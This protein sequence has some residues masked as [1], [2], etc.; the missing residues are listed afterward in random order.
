MTQKTN[1]C[2]IE[3]C[4][5]PASAR[6]LCPRHYVR[7]RRH[8]DPTVV[9]PPGAPRNVLKAMARQAIGIPDKMSERTFNRFWRAMG[10][11]KWLGANAGEAAEQRIWDAARRPNGRFNVSKLHDLAVEALRSAVKANPNLLDKED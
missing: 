10:I 11:L 9:K 8:G 2:A 5:A 7:T 3:G 6:G 4:E 1:S